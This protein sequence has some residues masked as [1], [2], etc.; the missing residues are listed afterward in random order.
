MNDVTRILAEARAGDPGATG[1]LFDLVYAE[2]RRI[3]AAKM[4]HEAAASTLQ[5][6]ALVHEAWLRLGGD[7]APAWEN[8]AHFFSAAAEAMRRILVEQARRRRTLRRGRDPE[9]V[10][11]TD[12][13]LPAPE[14]RGDDLL[15]VH[16]ALD[17]LARS[18][19]DKA[20][21]VKLRYFMGLNLDEAAAI[22]G[23][24]LATAKRQWTFA[25][26]WL[27]RELHRR[28]SE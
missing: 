3:A 7:A 26:A 28:A 16:E 25:R 2:L 1:R 24:S 18:H 5:P 23:V 19:P 20:E 10:P 8:R 6:T 14:Q 13:D 22:L 4:A 9:R 15:R 12:L 21:L 11:L 17:A 27:L